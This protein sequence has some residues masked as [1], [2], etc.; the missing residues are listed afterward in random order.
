MN[1]IKEIY[2]ADNI[3]IAAETGMRKY[4]SNIEG[5]YIYY[6]Q[7]GWGWTNT[8]IAA[9]KDERSELNGERSIHIEFSE[10]IDGEF[11]GQE[12]VLYNG[13]ENDYIYIENSAL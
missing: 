2:K 3:E 7:K 10:V 4:N 11:V 1:T 5:V 9:Q 8:I 6:I 13:L 12:N